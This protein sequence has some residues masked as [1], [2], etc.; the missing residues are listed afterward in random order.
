MTQL[1]CVAARYPHKGMKTR[2]FQ[3]R[4]GEIRK[5]ICANNARFNP[6]ITV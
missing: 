5:K 4:I 3:Q 6:F 1:V 2:R